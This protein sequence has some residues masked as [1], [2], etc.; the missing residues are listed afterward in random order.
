MLLL[1]RQQEPAR[2]KEEGQEEE[3]QEDIL[4][5]QSDFESESRTEQNDSGSQVSEHLPL[6]GDEEEAVSEV[7]EGASNYG[8]RT[9]ADYSD[10]SVS[11]STR[12][13]DYSATEKSLSRGRNSRSSAPQTTPPQ[14]RAAARQGLKEAAVQ[15]DNVAHTR[16]TG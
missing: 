12:T 3:E 7:S 15:T 16:L 5:Y 9:E 14:R 1:Q 10:R 11:R 6:D 2:Y 4:N 8:T 13:P